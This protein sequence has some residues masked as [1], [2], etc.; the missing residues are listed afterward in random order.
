MGVVP[1]GLFSGIVVPVAVGEVF[2]FTSI[3]GVL[4]PGG[5]FSSTLLIVVSVVSTSRRRDRL[6][7]FISKATLH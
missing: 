4:V 1:C 5:L 6:Y 3:M 7:S 2:S